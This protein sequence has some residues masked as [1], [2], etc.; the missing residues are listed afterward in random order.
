MTVPRASVIVPCRNAADTVAEAISG[1]LASP[2]REI[3]VLA[4]DDGSDDGTADVVAGLS[5]RDPRVRLLRNGGNGVSSARNAGLDAANS[6]SSWMP[7][8]R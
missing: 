6:S 8:T 5:R 3:E 1:I 2:L 4:V 7:T